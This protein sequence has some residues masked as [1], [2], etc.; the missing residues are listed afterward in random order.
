MRYFGNRMTCA[1]RQNP[2]R[3][4]VFSYSLKTDKVID[5]CHQLDQTWT[6]WCLQNLAHKE[7]DPWV[8]WLQHSPHCLDEC[9]WLEHRNC[10]GLHVRPWQQQIIAL[11]RKV[12]QMGWFFSFSPQDSTQLHF[13]SLPGK[14]TAWKR[15]WRKGGGEWNSWRQLD[16]TRLKDQEACFLCRKKRK[17]SF[18]S[19]W[20]LCLL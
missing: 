3:F 2:Y 12:H 8:I 4:F 6:C 16:W 14:K 20:T 5:K 1:P 13:L 9:K 19:S 15:E 17:R 7:L 18:D 11:A 10:S